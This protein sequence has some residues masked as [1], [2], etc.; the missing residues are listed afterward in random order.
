VNLFV[1]LYLCFFVLYILYF[2]LGKTVLGLEL[3]QL[4]T[5]IKTL[6]YEERIREIEHANFSPLVFSTIGGMGPFNIVTR[7][8]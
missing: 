3:M 2:L 6:E 8:L 5:N 1:C 4:P 7:R